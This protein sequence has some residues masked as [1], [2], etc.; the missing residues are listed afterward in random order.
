MTPAEEMPE[1]YAEW[2]IGTRN[3]QVDGGQGPGEPPPN[4]PAS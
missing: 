1:R 2:L 3:V 4:V